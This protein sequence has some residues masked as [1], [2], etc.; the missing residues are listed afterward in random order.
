[1]LPKLFGKKEMWSIA[2]RT[3]ALH[4]SEER[5]RSMVERA[6]ELADLICLE[7]GK[8][9][10]DEL[11]ESQERWLDDIAERIEKVQQ[12]CYAEGRKDEAEANEGVNRLIDA[13]A[14]EH[15][16]PV[17]WAKAV[18]IVAIVAKLTDT[19]RARLLALGEAQ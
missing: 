6:D 10:A 4:A 9:C 18:E 11:P 19:E 12:D 7:N 1:M 8:A 3:A 16:K 17:P 13:W 5:Y 15:G 2:E 14:A